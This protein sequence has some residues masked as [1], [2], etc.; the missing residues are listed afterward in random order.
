MRTR[1]WTKHASE[2]FPYIT[3]TRWL[4]GYTTTTTHLFCYTAFWDPIL[5]SSLSLWT[6]FRFFFIQGLK[7][8]L[9]GKH[10]PNIN[11]RTNQKLFY[12][13]FSLCTCCKN[14]F[15]L[16][17]CLNLLRHLAAVVWS[18]IEQSIL[19]NAWNCWFCGFLL[20]S[21]KGLL[22]HCR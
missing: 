8:G 14:F 5:L 12:F 9:A 21:L 1:C 7:W 13:L 20:W 19:L 22:K 4:T 6:G 16:K 10:S 18:L 17:Y 2:L 15:F 3:C 11:D